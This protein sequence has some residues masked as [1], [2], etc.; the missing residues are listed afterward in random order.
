MALQLWL[1]NGVRLRLITTSGV[2]FVIWDAISIF[3]DQTEGPGFDPR[4]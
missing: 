1:S 4:K 2:L 3:T